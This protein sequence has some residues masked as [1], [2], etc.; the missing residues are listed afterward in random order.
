MSPPRRRAPATTRPKPRLT[1]AEKED[2]GEGTTPKPVKDK[3]GEGKEADAA[4]K[5]EAEAEYDEPSTG[6]L[7]GLIDTPDW[8][9]LGGSY[10]HLNVLELGEDDPFATFPMQADLYGQMRLG[11]LQL[12]GSIGLAKVAPGSPHARRAQS[13]DDRAG[14]SIQHDLALALGGSGL[15]IRV[16]VLG[17]RGTH[18][19]ALRLAHPGAHDVGP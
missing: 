4:V 14:R 9:M 11:M 6:F 1:A 18:Q 13:G 3:A 15:R 2:S 5:E 10:R 17:T 8:L 16:R 19:L 7:W 12:G